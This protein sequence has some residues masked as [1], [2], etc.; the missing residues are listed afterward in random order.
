[1]PIRFD[2][3]CG[4][5]IVVDDQ[6]CGKRCICPS[7]RKRLF[8]PLQRATSARTELAARFS[9]KFNAP[10]TDAVLFRD[11]R[12]ALVSTSD[13]YVFLV[14]LDKRK[15]RVVKE[16]V[17]TCTNLSLRLSSDDRHALIECEYQN[18]SRTSH[19]FELWD[20]S[21]RANLGGWPLD[22]PAD[23]MFAPVG[24]LAFSPDGQF[25]ARAGKAS[26]KGETI[27][28]GREPDAVILWTR[29][30][31]DLSELY[32]MDAEFDHG[33][34]VAFSPDGKLLAAAGN[35]SLDVA[36]AVFQREEFGEGE[37][38]VTGK[39]VRAVVGKEVVPFP[40]SEQTP[41][42]PRTPDIMIWDVATRRL[43]YRLLHGCRQQLPYV[44]EDGAGRVAF[45]SCGRR[46]VSSSEGAL[47]LWRLTSTGFQQ[48]AL[49]GA[50]GS[51]GV[52]PDLK[53]AI[54]YPHA[55]GEPQC[56]QIGVWEISTRT[57]VPISFAGCEAHG[58]VVLSS[59]GRHVLIGDADQTLRL[60]DLP[61]SSG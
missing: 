38:V 36:R 15:V 24:P 31:G 34:C 37:E 60:Y 44:T 18:T 10:L 9:F 23:V 16:V 20:I 1:M 25:G 41:T 48:S 12:Q 46:L 13:G 45:S 56:Q 8:V 26:Y 2:C 33:S 29:K 4:K 35:W 21:K 22:W 28:S 39:P 17:P 49:L 55:E 61:S 51:V 43:R 30:Q 47:S 3:L 27:D 52:T 11:P 50:F 53:W 32:W 40:R 5:Q 42:G 58:M 59:D 54:G 19:K 6:H 14:R 57:E 7:C